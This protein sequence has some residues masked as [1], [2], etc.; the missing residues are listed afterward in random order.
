V[1]VADNGRLALEMISTGAFDLVRLD[2]TM[3]GLS[4]YQVLQHL[5]QWETGR[6]LPVI[7][8]SALDEIDRAVR[9]IEPG[10]A[11]YW[12]K[13]FNP[14][15]LRARVQACLEK[16]RLR[17]LKGAQQR[18]LT[19]LNAA[20]E[21]RNRC[22]RRTFGSYLSD[23]IGD[24]IRVIFGA[25]ILPPD[26]P[27]RAVAC[28]VEMQL[29]M[30]AVNE[31]NRRAGYPEVAL[32]MGINT[33]DV[34]MDNMGSQKRIKYAAVGAPSTSRPALNPLR[35][36]ARSLFPKAPSEPVRAGK[37]LGSQGA[38]HAVEPHLWAHQFHSYGSFGPLF[39]V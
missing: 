24:G 27:R 31:R 22:I 4:D 39:P 8:I 21:L 1:Q 15:L 32:G 13:P 38:I 20:L 9:G 19:E 11:D 33:G 14:V 30:A 17:D 29:A 12:R 7:M 34:V 3:P 25:P 16:K 5:K 2:I 37:V 6:D 35:W 36:A 28:A 10:A 26:D 23:E 18:Q